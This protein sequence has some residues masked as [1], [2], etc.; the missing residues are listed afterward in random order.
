MTDTESIPDRTT[1]V[2]YDY[3]VHSTYS[4]GRHLPRMVRAAAEAGLAGVGIADHCMV[5]NREV[6]QDARRQ[7]GFNLDITYKR[8]RRAIETLRDRF[9][10][11]IYDAVEV[12]YHPAD[13]AA[14]DAFLDRAGFEYSLGSVHTVDDVN[15]HDETYFA[16]LSPTERTAVVD[17]YF[18]R[19][20]ALIESDRFDIA[21]HL[22]LT[23][24]NPALRGIAT[25]DHYRRVADALVESRTIPELNAGRILEEYGAFH[26]ANE[27]IELLCARDVPF[28]AGSD[29]H[30][31]G[32]LADRV[33]RL[34]Q[35]FDDLGVDPT[36][37]SGL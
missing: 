34:D 27:F 19:V 31:P 4:D 12:D 14:I 10:I 8:R 22:D 6:F 16:E 23:E 17:T 11:A 32:S 9:D 33:D 30:D 25:T 20:V 35:R 29:S 13:E 5:T 3:H 36:T 18:D 37:V 1:A 7:F 26:P 2:Q 24:R 15:L 21:A 28:V